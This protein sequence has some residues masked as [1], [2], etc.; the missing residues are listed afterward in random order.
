MFYC[1]LNPAQIC[2]VC[3]ECEKYHSDTIENRKKS[4]KD[5]ILKLFDDKIKI[6]ENDL[7]KAVKAGM[8]SSIIY[9]EIDT[10]EILKNEIIEIFEC[11]CK[12]KERKK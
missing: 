11:Y 10:L 12:K 1:I 8:P 5:L 6:L 7:D 3:Y 4:S 9:D 2:C